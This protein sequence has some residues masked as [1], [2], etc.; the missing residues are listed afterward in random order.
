MVILLV[1]HFIVNEGKRY[2]KL[3]KKFMIDFNVLYLFLHL[4]SL[5]AHFIIKVNVL[6]RKKD[7]IIEYLMNHLNPLKN[8]DS[9]IFNSK[10]SDHI[11]CINFM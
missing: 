3:K 2:P 1:Y 6:I 8:V 4:R 5:L 11:L 10:E 9:Y 7:K